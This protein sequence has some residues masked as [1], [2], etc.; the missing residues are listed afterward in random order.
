MDY[1]ELVSE[2]S[3]YDLQHLQE[4]IDAR[5]KQLDSMEKVA[6]YLVA[7]WYTVYGYFAEDNY[8]GAVAEVKRLFDRLD[9]RDGLTIRKFKYNANEASEK[10]KN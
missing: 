10:L 4:K 8:A 1:T 7:D 9:W 5:Q 3:V 6:L 2:L